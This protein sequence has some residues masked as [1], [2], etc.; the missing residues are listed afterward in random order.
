MMR[1]FLLCLLAW[2]SL[3]QAGLALGH[4]LVPGEVILDTAVLQ[5]SRPERVVTLPHALTPGD[6][7]PQGST[8]RFRIDLTLA[9]LPGDLAIYIEKTSR[10]G[11]V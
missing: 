2:A 11:R 5:S 1:R 8:V 7:D 3:L 9:T 10:P 6:F 4:N